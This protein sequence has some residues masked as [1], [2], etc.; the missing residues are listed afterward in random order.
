MRYFKYLCQSPRNHLYFKV[1]SFKCISLSLYGIFLK[2]VTS[3]VALFWIFSSSLISPCLYGHHTKFAYSR[4]GRTIDLF[5]NTKLD[6]S[7]CIK[8]LSMIPKIQLNFVN[9]D[10]DNT[11]SR[12][13]RTYFISPAKSPWFLQRAAMLALQ[14]L[15]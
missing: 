14:A 6:S 15:Y 12:F 10:S 4:C 3:L 11:D 5:N 8:F 1:G 13:T 9:M 7:M 2:F